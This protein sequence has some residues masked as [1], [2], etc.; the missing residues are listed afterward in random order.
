MEFSLSSL[1]KLILS[2]I[3]SA[4]LGI[5]REIRKKPAGL[6]THI[7]VG[8]GSTLFTILS[9][10]AFPNDPARVASY[11]VA[12]IGFIGAGA[13]IKEKDRVIGLTTASSLWLTSAVGMAIGLGYFL[14]AFIATLLGLLTL[15]LGKI[16]KEKSF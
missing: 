14:L 10:N 13:I 11:I 16:E 6:R 9:Y 1:I 4:L 2:F 8:L 12:G 15:L 5:E 3:F 7:L